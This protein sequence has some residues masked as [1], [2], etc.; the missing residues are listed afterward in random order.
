M[1]WKALRATMPDGERD[2]MRV[3]CRSCGAEYEIPE[4]A[5]R[6]P[7]RLRCAACGTEW[8]W[9]GLEPALAEAVVGAPDAA[10]DPE[11]R[12]RFGREPSELSAEPMEA[13]EPFDAVGP[14]RAPFPPSP[15]PM[16][17]PVA[18][19]RGSGARLVIAAGGVGWL[20]AWCLTIL[21]IAAAGWAWWHWR[22]PIARHWPSSLWLYRLLPGGVP[23]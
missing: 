9:A 17:S 18:S 7:R 23:A 14:P 2:S 11:P 6:R 10:E 4:E 21:L 16:A 12:P 13:D 3:A 5:L 8:Q 22:V 1:R 15:A 20:A 19:A